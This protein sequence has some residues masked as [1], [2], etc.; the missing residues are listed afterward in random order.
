[1]RP[2]PSILLACLC[3][4]PFASA[5]AAAPAL[6]QCELSGSH[7]V[8]R[9]EAVCGRLPRPENPE[10]PDGARLDLFIAK[11]PSLSPEP[12]PD[13]FT[14]INGGPG[15]SSVSLFVDLAQAFSGVLR[16]R[17]IVL[18]DQ[19]GTG[20]SNA[21]ECP[22]LEKAAED[23]SIEAVQEAT[24]ACLES[25]AG[26]PRFYTTSQAVQDL[27]AVRAALGYERL[28]VYGVSYGTRVSMHY[29][30]RYPDRVRTLILDG[31]V[32]PGLALGVN[33]AEN[34][35]RRL[36]ELFA[37]CDRAPE[38][39]EAF[40][41]LQASFT[42]LQSNLNAEPVSLRFPNPITGLEES[43]AFGYDH[44]ALVVRLLSYA[45]E[46]ASLLPLIIDQA[47]GGNYLPAASQ[48]LRI[49]DALSGT[50]SFGMHNSVTCTEDLPFIDF[51]QVN[52]DALEA[53]Y[54]GAD[55][56]RALRAICEIW[57]RGA[58]DP[59]LKD[60]VQADTPTLILSGELDP[61]TPPAYGDQ[62]KPGFGNSM[63]IIGAGQGH[64]VVSRGCLP[65]L[66]TQMV[67][68]GHLGD[69]DAGCVERLSAA[70][71][72]I[73]LMGPAP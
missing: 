61:I 13:A 36:D 48:A 21:L 65:G 52:W 41:D 56:V 64:G 4:L 29:L 45:P 27:E 35:Q 31:V 1:V 71:F 25:L 24:R 58:M 69:L 14:I 10:Q 39:S 40:P 63:H 33:V 23:Y 49:T 38:C 26:D 3:F 37:Q 67:E 53:T 16:E 11:I 68:A 59:D 19:R 20:R 46:T 62:I 57:P 72:F 54:I 17:D 50:M 15:A 60:P 22:E 44:L 34:A 70:P 6:E 7:G 12:A 51:N 43:L 30:R 9:V 66:V 8:G 2:A 55:Q 5:L 28:N 18:V 42:Q 47:A 32:P 73:D